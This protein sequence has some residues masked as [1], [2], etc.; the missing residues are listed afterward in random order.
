MKLIDISLFLPFVIV[1]KGLNCITCKWR[2]LIF[3]HYLF[4]S[5]NEQNI[6]GSR[7]EGGGAALMERQTIRGTEKKCRVKG[8][9]QQSIFYFFGLYWLEIIFPFTTHPSFC[10][11]GG[12]RV[13]INVWWLKHSRITVTHVKSKWHAWA[14]FPGHYSY[15]RLSFRYMMHSIIWENKTLVILYGIFEKIEH[16]KAALFMWVGA[17][18][19]IC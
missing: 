12:W 18:I 6:S 16:S 5:E 4:I 8:S 1:W 14:H 9:W 2:D 17:R 15:L 3:A 10:V 11:C 19:F 7:N 13:I